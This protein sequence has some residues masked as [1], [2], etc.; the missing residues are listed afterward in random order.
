MASD[1]RFSQYLGHPRAKLPG[2]RVVL[3]QPGQVNVVRW[4]LVEERTGDSEV[5]WAPGALPN[6]VTRRN[7][8][9]LRHTNPNIRRRRVA[10]ASLMW[11]YGISG[12][13]WGAG[14]ASDISNF[15]SPRLDAVLAECEANL[16]T[17]AIAEA[18]K[19]NLFHP[20]LEVLVHT[21]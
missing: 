13:R 11:G 8:I 3:N 20:D 12:A 16:T 10:I 1:E 18:Y 15:L 5:A 14:W 6:P 4:R 7:I 19:L 17:G 2:A 9:D 21:A